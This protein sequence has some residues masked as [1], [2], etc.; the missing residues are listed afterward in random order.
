MIDVQVQIQALQQQLAA[1]QDNQAALLAAIKK[2]EDLIAR[3]DKAVAELFARVADL[4]AQIRDLNDKADTL[5]AQVKDLEVRVNRLRTDISIADAKKTKYLKDIQNLQDQ[6]SIQRKLQVPDSLNKINDMINSLRKMLPT[7]QSEIDRHY[8]YCFGNGKVQV[9]QTGSVVV[10]VVRGDAFANYLRTLYGSN[11]VLPAINGDVL[12]NR[13]DIF[14]STWVGAFGYP[15]GNGALG[16]NDL[17]IGGSFGCTNPGALVTGYG[18]I[19]S[20][21]AGHIECADAKGGK[22]RF[23]LGSC[24][25]LESTKSLPTVGQQFYWSG[26]QGSNGYNLYAGSCF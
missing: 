5:S 11:V 16:G 17:S 2:S 1:L 18:T 23:S 3:N 14:G 6:I 7:V 26:V 21:G 4:E 12:F 19:T 10:Y 20:V 15:F 9:Q 8:Y 24:S 22:Q 25:R 13:V